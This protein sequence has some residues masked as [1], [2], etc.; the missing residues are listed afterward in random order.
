MGLCGKISS[1][2]IG[3]EFD[4]TVVVDSRVVTNHSTLFKNSVLSIFISDSL[5]SKADW[6]SIIVTSSSMK[7]YPAGAICFC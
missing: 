4:E 6:Y 1:F 3:P 2:S 7:Q 5:F